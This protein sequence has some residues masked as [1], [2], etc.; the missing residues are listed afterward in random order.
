MQF[1]AVFDGHGGH[2][3]SEF[4]RDNLHNLIAQSTFFPHNLERAMQDG[5]ETAERM[6]MQQNLDIV[7]DKSGSC[8]IICLLCDQDVYIANVGDSRAITS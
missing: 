8:A 1:F 5:C 6:F 3:C 7:R 2:G 4:L